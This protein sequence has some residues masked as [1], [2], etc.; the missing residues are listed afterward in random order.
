MSDVCRQN[1]SHEGVLVLMAVA[2]VMVLA[3]KLI[4][5]MV[6]FIHFFCLCQLMCVSISWGESTPQV[7]EGEGG[8]P[9]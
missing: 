8:Q 4:V 9:R 2:A 1:D 5:V 3:V 7:L 6:L